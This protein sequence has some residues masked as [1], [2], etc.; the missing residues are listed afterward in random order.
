[1]K[2]ARREDIRHYIEA[3][4]EVTLLE[5]QEMFPDCSMMTLRRDLIHLEEEGIVKRTRG[6]AV[7]IDRLGGIIDGRYSQRVMDHTSSKM[8]I[9]GKPST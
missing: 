5:L 9:A 6:G 1:M 7:S 4:G 8:D 2:I 3:K